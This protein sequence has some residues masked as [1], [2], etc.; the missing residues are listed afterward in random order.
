MYRGLAPTQ[1]DMRYAFEVV[2]GFAP[3]AVSLTGAT[4][5]ILPVAMTTIPGYDQLAVVDSQDRGLMLISL[6][7]VGVQTSFY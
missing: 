6:R 5:V 2:G 4:N 7:T 1:R 3:L